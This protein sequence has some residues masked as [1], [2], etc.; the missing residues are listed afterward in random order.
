MRSEIKNVLKT[1]LWNT[2][3]AYLKDTHAVKGDSVI[4]VYHGLV[5][6]HHL[7][8]NMRFLTTGVFKK[9]MQLFKNTCNMVTVQ[10]IYENNIDKNALNVAITFDDGYKNNHTYAAPILDAMQIPAAFFITTVQA[11]GYNYLWTD[12]LDITSFYARGNLIVDGKTFINHNK[13]FLY[14]GK[15]LKQYCKD[16]DWKFKVQMFEAMKPFKSALHHA[17]NK[18]YWEL[19][20]WKELVELANNKLFTLGSHGL[21]HNNLENVT[22]AEAIFELRTSKLYLEKMTQKTID[23]FAYPDGS[24]DHALIK[25]ADAAGYKYQLIVSSKYKQ[26]AEDKRLLQ[27]F[28]VN[29]YLNAPG[30]MKYMIRRKY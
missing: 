16:A 3:A 10:D 2:K 5:P 11:G 12:F 25:I 7:K 18:E 15:T 19:L 24:Y 21:Y 8:F 26:D 13:G 28:T 27:R 9:H 30:Q 1:L 14:E 20:G 22:H 29:P 23:H 6:K 4:L 17:P